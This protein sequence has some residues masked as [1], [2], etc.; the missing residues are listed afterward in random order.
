MWNASME[1]VKIKNILVQD[2]L[3]IPP[4]EYELLACNEK[5]PGTLD[6]TANVRW[7]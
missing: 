1:D 6:E 3:N 2:A 4:H 7:R 5:I